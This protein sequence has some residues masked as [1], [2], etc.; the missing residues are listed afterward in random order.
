MLEREANRTLV[1]VAVACVAQASYFTGVAATST[2]QKLYYEAQNSM[3]ACFCTS[4]PDTC[5]YDNGDFYCA[6]LH[7][8]GESDLTFPSLLVSL[9]DSSLRSEQL[10]CLR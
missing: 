5:V 4:P 8:N 1:L 9:T 3:C 2:G 6:D 10:W 7:G